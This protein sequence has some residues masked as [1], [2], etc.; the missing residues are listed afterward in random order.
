MDTLQLLASGPEPDALFQSLDQQNFL[1][2][3]EK[4]SGLFAWRGRFQAHPLQ[5]EVRWTWPQRFY[6]EQFILTGAPRHLAYWDEQSG[7]TLLQVAQEETVDS[8][9]AIYQKLS[10]PYIEPELREG[11]FEFDLIKKNK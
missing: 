4:A 7:H 1:I 8:E 6:S 2:K 10:L 5:V 11:Y 3:D 9:E